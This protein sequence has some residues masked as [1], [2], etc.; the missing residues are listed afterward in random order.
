MASYDLLS[1]Q[2]STG[3]RAGLLLEQRIVVDI[4]DGLGV[5]DCSVLGLLEDWQ[6]TRGRLADVAGDSKAEH[7]P[8]GSVQLL[9]P[10][11]YPRGIFAAAAN[12]PDHIYE[13][14]KV[15]LPPKDEARP[16]FFQKTGAHSV[17]GPGAE[18]RFPRTDSRVCWESELGVVIGRPARNVSAAGA[19]GYVAGCVIVNDLSNGSMSRRSDWF[20]QR[21]GSDWLRVKSFDNSA[22]MGP[23]LT[24]AENVP[25][26]HDLMIRCWINK[27]LMQEGNTGTMHYNINEQIEYLS[28]Q[29][30]LLPGDVISTGTLAGVGAPKGI[31][32][33]PGDEITITIDCLGTLKNRVV[34]G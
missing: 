17:V 22:P 7:K 34:A 33:K 4:A 31:F 30:T 2:S 21:F 23:W 6:R 18:L 28:E 27:Q 29:L 14:A 5:A 10:I 9:A 11:L 19:P 20:G 16:L 26:P 3:P 13:W 24:L 1:Y 32:L 12:Y 25:D 8:L 15:E